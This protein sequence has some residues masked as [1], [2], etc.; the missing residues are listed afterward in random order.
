MF[1]QSNPLCILLQRVIQY[2]AEISIIPFPKS[3]FKN[4]FAYSAIARH[5]SKQLEYV[6][7]SAFDIVSLPHKIFDKQ[8][9]HLFLYK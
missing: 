7:F 3:L 5:N 8:F 2:L 6:F 9:F 4:T 1:Y